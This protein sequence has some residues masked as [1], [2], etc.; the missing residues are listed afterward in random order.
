MANIF[1]KVRNAIEIFKSIDL[2]ELSKI[3]GKVDLPKMMEGFEKMDDK[4]IK[5]MMRVTD[6]EKKKNEL[7]LGAGDCYDVFETFT[8][9]QTEIQVR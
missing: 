4:Q 5:M 2:D 1:S 8:P 6:P 9:A 3:S 7:T